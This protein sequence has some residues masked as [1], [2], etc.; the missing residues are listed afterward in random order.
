[1]K[2]ITIPYNDFVK[3]HTKLIRVLKDGS[4]KAQ[5]KEAASQKKELMGVFKHLKNPK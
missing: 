4:K 3:E 1:M 2:G 5:M